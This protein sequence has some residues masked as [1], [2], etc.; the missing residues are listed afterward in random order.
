MD[1]LKNIISSELIIV[2][3]I[4][5]ISLSGCLLVGS[6]QML[7]IYF[8]FKKCISLTKEKDG[9]GERCPSNGSEF[10]A[11]FLAN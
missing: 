11:N 6:F 2:E 9:V 1:I 8:Q 7:L 4:R 10:R 3:E 5:T